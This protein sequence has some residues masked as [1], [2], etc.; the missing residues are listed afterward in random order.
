MIVSINSTSEEVRSHFS[1]SGINWLLR[2]SINSTSEEVRSAKPTYRQIFCFIIVSIN[3]TS[4]EVRSGHRATP[5]RTLR[6]FPLIQLPR[7]SE[8]L[9]FLEEHKTLFLN[10]FH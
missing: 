8:V 9:L 7:K 2:V 1:P 6:R 4:E 10:S 3:S 5:E